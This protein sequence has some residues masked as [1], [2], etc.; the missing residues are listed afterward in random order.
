MQGRAGKFASTYFLPREFGEPG[1]ERRGSRLAE[2]DKGGGPFDER[3]KTKSQKRDPPAG[4]LLPSC[5]GQ[6][7]RQ[8]GAQLARQGGRRC[9]ELQLRLQLWVLSRPRAGHI[10]RLRRVG[11][12]GGTLDFARERVKKALPGRVKL[13]I[14]GGWKDQNFP[15]CHCSVCGRCCR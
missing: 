15:F 3:Y 13:G 9:A 8:L 14:P 7:R 1:P 2:T 12:A 10:R 4:R 11:G 6:G 5:Y